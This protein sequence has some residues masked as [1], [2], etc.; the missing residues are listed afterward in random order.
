MTV[1]GY[2]IP[3]IDGGARNN[4]R[5]PNYHR[6]DLSLTFMQLGKPG[7]KKSINDELVVSVYNVYARQNPFSIYFSQGSERQGDTNIQTAAK[8]MSMLGTLIPAV[9]YNF[10]F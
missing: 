8:Q 5:A 9:S 1:N 4:F 10:K 3:Y 6:L 7:K 2:V